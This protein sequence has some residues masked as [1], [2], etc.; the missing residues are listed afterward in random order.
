MRVLH[1]NSYYSSSRFY[2][3]LYDQQLN[4]GLDVNVIVPVSS[5]VSKIEYDMGDYTDLRMNHKKMDR[6]FFNM[7]HKKIYED[8]S[9]NYNVPSYSLIH[10]HSLF[11]NGI[12]AMKLKKKYGIPYIVAVRNTDVNIFFKRMIHLRKLGLEILDEAS[13]IVFIS[14]NYRNLVLENYVPQHKKE[15]IY[16]KT[17]IIPNGI[18]EYYIEN[19]NYKKSIKNYD[20]LKI[21]YVG[22]IDKNKNLITT[23]KAINLL[24]EEGY[25]VCFTVV[26]KVKEK[27]VFNKI[28]KISK[29]NYIPPI[30]KED[31]IE[32]YNDNHIFVMPSIKETF[33]LVYA[34]A[35][36]QGLP[37][38][39][40]KGQGFDKQ[41]D[42]GEVGYS[43]DCFNVEEIAGKVKKILEEYH[44]ISKRSSEYTSKFH[45]YEINLEYLDLYNETL[46]NKEDS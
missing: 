4:N 41:F 36:S 24:K 7:K 40:T 6:Y 2:K 17:T 15:K 38:I 30:P 37:V 28:N 44:I 39:Y 35:I 8:I 42:E 11:S 5:S 23:V 43:V 46:F 3:N 22:N 16:K 27:R 19:R 9:I 18:D 10:A 20:T 1:I 13:K 26:G 29:I 34:E 33:G 12:V 32:I 31:L 21:L 14:K 25:N 45:W